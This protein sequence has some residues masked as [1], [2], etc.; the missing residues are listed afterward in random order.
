MHA[1]LN[2]AGIFGTFLS[3]FGSWDSEE[4]SLCIWLWVELI[5]AGILETFFSAFGTP[6]KTLNILAHRN[7][8]GR[9][10][11]DIF[12]DFVR[13]KKTLN[14]LACGNKLGRCI[15]DIP[16]LW[17]WYAKENSLFKYLQ[18]TL[19]LEI[20]QCKAKFRPFWIKFLSS[21]LALLCARI[22]MYTIR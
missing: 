11:W 18:Q 9:H 17:F 7:K 15:W 13:L 5:W 22:P 4:N 14:I 8:L 16:I 20:I 21:C 10:I 1:K 12:S 6:K 3:A 2:R 19:I